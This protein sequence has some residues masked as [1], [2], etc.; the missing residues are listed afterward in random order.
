MGISPVWG[1]ITIMGT[2][3]PKLY[4]DEKEDL[5]YSPFIVRERE[6]MPNLEVDSKKDFHAPV[7]GMSDEEK[8]KSA[9]LMQRKL[10]A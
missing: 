3:S 7:A 6:K 2:E 5:G 8:T 10:S 9:E 1:Q 4:F